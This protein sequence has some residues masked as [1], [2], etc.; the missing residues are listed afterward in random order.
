M[1]R[2][3]AL[4]LALCLILTGCG[5]MDGSYQSVTPHRQHSDGG[6][7]TIEAA[8]SYLQLRTAL[9]NM[10]LSGTSSLRA[11]LWMLPIWWIEPPTASNNAVQPRAKYSFSVS[12]G[13]LESG[14]RS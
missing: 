14:R 3:A 9:E 6:E 7:T 2:F 8:D 5:W 1:K 4:V 13:I 11:Y 10:V 12:L